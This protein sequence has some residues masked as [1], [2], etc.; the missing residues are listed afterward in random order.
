[1][2]SP[3]KKKSRRAASAGDGKGAA[4]GEDEGGDRLPRTEEKDEGGAAISGCG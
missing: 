2:S 4:D 3:V 1:L